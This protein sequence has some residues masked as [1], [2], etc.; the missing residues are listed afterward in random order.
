MTAQRYYF[1]DFVLDPAQ[2]QLLC[3]SQQLELNARYLDALVLLVQDAGKLIS[4]QRFFDEVW[5]GTVVTDEALTQCIRNLRRQLQDSASAPRFIE[6]VPKHGYRFIAA[7]SCSSPAAAAEQSSGQPGRRQLLWHL[8]GQGALGAAI[9]GLIGG[10]LYGLVGAAQALATGSQ[11]LSVLLVMLTVTTLIAILAGAAVSSGLV[12]AKMWLI[13][14]PGQQQKQLQLK[15]LGYLLLGGGA[16]GLLIGAFVS[17]LL[18]E[19]FLLF[20]GRSPAHITGATEGLIIGLA[21]GISYWLLLTAR[22]SASRQRFNYVA[23]F[24]AAVPGLLAGLLISLGGGVLLAGSLAQ[25]ATEFPDA[26]AAGLL[27]LDGFSPAQG[28]S[29]A[30]GFSISGIVSAMLEAGLFTTGLT[31]GLTSQPLRG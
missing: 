25:L 14:S 18:Q 11:A 3:G 31:L 26:A 8:T 28:F 24:Q 12:L 19:T 22:R 29:T 10:G 30:Q 20:L 9:A 1:A 13:K 23:V 27:A 6:T 21:A 17:L 16:A 2:R 7:V 15:K 4:K 5:Q